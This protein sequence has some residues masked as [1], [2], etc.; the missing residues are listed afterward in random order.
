MTYLI[1]ATVVSSLIASF[2]LWE[3]WRGAEPVVFKVL[4]TILVLVPILGPISYVWIRNWPEINPARA[5]VDYRR[6]NYQDDHLIGQDKF[7][8][9]LSTDSMSPSRP[10]STT[11]FTDVNGR[12]KPKEALFVAG[13][14]LGGLALTQLWLLVVLSLTGWSDP[15]DSWAIKVQVFA[16]LAVLVVATLAFIVLVW[17][18]WFQSK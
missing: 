4:L 3:I 5:R 13:A 16:I 10:K 6:T 17:R 8:T 15:T 18:R 2:L 9:R 7:R 1:A 12:R 14:I 11:D